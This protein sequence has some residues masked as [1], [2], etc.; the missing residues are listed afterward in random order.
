V[1]RSLPRAREH[2]W[3][4]FSFERRCGPGCTS[5][6]VRKKR[7]KLFRAAE[8]DAPVRNIDLGGNLAT[9]YTIPVG[10]G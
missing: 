1:I 10:A 5:N 4:K 6:G 2:P 8:Y 9:S 7:R 3:G